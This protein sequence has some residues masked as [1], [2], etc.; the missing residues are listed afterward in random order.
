MPAD[1]PEW[2]PA[3]HAREA[4]L[5]LA[6]R[7]AL[8]AAG[9]AGEETQVVRDEGDVALREGDRLADIYGLEPCQ[10]V[11]VGVD[12]VGQ[13][14]EHAGALFRGR[15]EPDVIESLL[16]RGDGAVDVLLVCDR[17]LG[18]HVPGGGI[19]VV[20][21]LA[22]GRVDPLATYEQRSVLLELL[23]HCRAP[24]CRSCPR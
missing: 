23:I 2:L 20:L 14:Q 12:G 9:R 18:D 3:D 1:D 22:L 16:R 11:A 8:L 5:V 24:F 4:P 19:D 6:A 13:L 15:V 17:D 10:L 21:G 7:L